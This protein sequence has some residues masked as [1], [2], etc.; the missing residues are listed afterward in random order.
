MVTDEFKTSDLGS[1]E[2]KVP[3]GFKNKWA[4][5]EMAHAHSQGLDSAMVGTAGGSDISMLQEQV[6]PKS[7]EVHV[8]NYLKP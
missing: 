5:Q 3:A 4:L 2:E 6:S 1:L 7:T 8:Q